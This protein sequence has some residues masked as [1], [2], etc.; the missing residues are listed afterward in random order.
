MVGRKDKLDSGERVFGRDV[1][2]AD[3]WG[4]GREVVGRKKSIGLGKSLNVGL[5][6]GE[7]RKKYS[8]K[9]LCVGYKRCGNSS[10]G[11]YKQNEILRIDTRS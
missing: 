11:G 7:W 8:E 4:S 6:S 10:T 3:R 2:V 1:E 9:R 5:R